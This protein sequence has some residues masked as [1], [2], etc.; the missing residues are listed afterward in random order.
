MML[1]IPAFIPRIDE[2]VERLMFKFGNC[3]RRAYSMKRKGIDRLEI[4]RI[5]RRETGLH[6][7]YVWTAYEMIKDLPP[8]VTFGGLRLQKLRERGKITKEEYQ[9]RRNSILACLGQARFKGNQC[10]R[11][12]GDELRVNAAPREWIYLPLF[13]PKRYEKYRGHLDGSK[14]Y[15]VLIKR[16]RDRKGCD[17]R[18]TIE[19]KAEI[20]GYKRVM[21]LDINAGH[22]DFA[23]VEKSNLNPIAFGKINCHELLSCKKEKNGLIVHKTANKIRNVA[24]H[25]GAEIV[26]GKLKTLSTKGCRRSNR[27]THLMSQYKLRQ[28]LSYKLPLNGVKFSERSEAHTSKVGEL[29]SKPMGI[30]IHKASAYAFAVKIIDYR[31]FMLLRGVR[32]NEGDGSPSAGLSGGSGLT[33]LRQFGLAHDEGLKPEA[34]PQYMV[35]AGCVKHLRC[36]VLHI[37]V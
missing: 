2:K 32:A 35:E 14:P 34:T 18:I 10:L 8:H 17:V 3:R 29:L 33:A 11:I 24:K 19:L 25:Y 1:T 16:R 4:I 27:K 21:A 20:L 37:R 23:V 6:T 7:R 22:V 13:I 9:K 15:T 28:V 26:A 5:L 36:P 30:D 31:T 12:V